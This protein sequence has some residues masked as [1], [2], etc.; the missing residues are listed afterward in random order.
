MCRML[1]RWIG[2]VLVNVDSF[3]FDPIFVDQINKRIKKAV[4]NAVPFNELE[5]K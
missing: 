3:A 4:K 1:C 5:N 2:N